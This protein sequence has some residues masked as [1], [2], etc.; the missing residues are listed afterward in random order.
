M[1][2]KNQKWMTAMAVAAVLCC[3]MTVS[4]QTKIMP[5][6]TAFDAQYYADTYPDV[7]AAFGTDEQALYRHYVEHGRAEG[8][9]AIAPDDS[10]QGALTVGIPA[11]FDAAYYAQSN[12]DVT[13]VY[14]TDPAALYRHYIEHGKAE[15]R[16]ANGNGAADVRTAQTAAKGNDQ[17]AVRAQVNALGI[18]YRPDLDAQWG[19]WAESLIM[20]HNL[21]EHKYKY[22]DDCWQF[23]GIEYVRG[24]Y[25]NDPLY[26]A[27]ARQLVEQREKNLRGEEQSDVI[28]FFGKVGD[29]SLTGQD[30][31]YLLN[32]T[33]NLRLDY[34]NSFSKKEPV[35]PVNLLSSDM[36]SSAYSMQMN[37]VWKM[38][39][40]SYCITLSSA[41]WK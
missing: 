2:K 5:D 3:E 25:T 19:R 37:L 29:I 17:N 30:P 40:G 22:E 14:G 11:D 36:D 12:P 27:L 4:A 32:L 9:R 1:R 8:R 24:D 41:L 35:Q 34:M 31:H 16:S 28:R 23:D 18:T 7:K 6:G 15:G 39:D 13:A 20:N 33:S 26:L 38:D 10:G 21:F